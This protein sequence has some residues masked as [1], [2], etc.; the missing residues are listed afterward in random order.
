VGG[1]NTPGEW[2]VLLSQLVIIFTIIFS[3]FILAHRYNIWQILG[4]GGILVGVVLAIVP[5][6]LSGSSQNIVWYSVIIFTSSNVPAAMSATVKEKY[7]KQAFIDI[8]WLTTLVSWLQ[9]VL[10]WV[11]VPLLSLPDF[12]GTPLSEI[13]SILSDG[14]KCFFGNP[15]IPV[16]NNNHIIGNCSYSVPIYTMAYSLS[17]FFAG[18]FF[19]IC[20]FKRKCRS[21]RYRNGDS[22]AVGELG[23]CI[24][25]CDGSGSGKILILECG[26]ICC[27]C[28][29]IWGVQL[30]WF[31]REE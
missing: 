29:R 3:Y 28:S 27:C 6:F 24:A 22:V 17:G 2:Q 25:L 15:T 11:F 21:L 10:T 31:G 13:P 20:Y 5:S 12:G 23:V 8:F 9:L 7:F 26:R 14:A 16:Y 18:I 19:L 1:V 4:T 30:F